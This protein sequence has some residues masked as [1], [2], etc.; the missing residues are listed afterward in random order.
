MEYKCRRS[1]CPRRASL[2][3]LEGAPF[4]DAILYVG[5][6]EVYLLAHAFAEASM[7]DY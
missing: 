1:F 3:E 4:G 5:L 2:F 6:Y 7:T